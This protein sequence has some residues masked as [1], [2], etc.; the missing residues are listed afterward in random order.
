MKRRLV[1]LLYAIALAAALLAGSSLR[2]EETG[3]VATIEG[4]VVD[5]HCYVTRG[6]EGADHAGCANACISRGV[7]AGFLAK[8]GTLYVLLEEKPFSVKDRVAG[9][10][11]IP[12]R[13]KGKIVERGGMK[14]LQIASLEKL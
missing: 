1:W 8:D 6:A 3:A 4:T 7:P 9:M 12:A 10:A 5:L 14:G 13:A 2:A 11:G